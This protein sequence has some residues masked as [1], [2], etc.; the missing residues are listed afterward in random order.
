MH[1]QVCCAPHLTNQ[2][3]STLHARN[4]CISAMRAVALMAGLCILIFNAALVSAACNLSPLNGVACVQSNS[5]T[6]NGSSSGMIAFPSNNTVGNVIV[7]ALFANG[8][9][10]ALPM[11]NRN[12][13]QAAVAN[14][15]Q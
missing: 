12:K 11:D 8:G 10:T 13:Y 14:Q 6:I 4:L 5:K 9:D 7:V 15:L 2:E 1:Y 3:K